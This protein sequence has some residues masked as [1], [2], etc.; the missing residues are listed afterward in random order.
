MFDTEEILRLK[1]SHDQEAI[2]KLFQDNIRLIQLMIKDKVSGLQDRDDMLQNAYFALCKTIDSWEPG[3]HSFISF[4]RM[5]I[6]S[7]NFAESLKMDYPVRLNNQNYKESPERVEFE[8]SE[9]M[10]YGFTEV[11][12]SLLLSDLLQDARLLLSDRQFDIVYQRVCNN[13]PLQVL[14]DKYGVTKARVVQIESRAFSILR[15]DRQFRE[16]YRSLV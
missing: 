5:N 7:I 3:K 8:D 11:E 12:N 2:A 16:R 9:Y 1:H 6:H 10:E 13:V 14:C 15:N 4:L